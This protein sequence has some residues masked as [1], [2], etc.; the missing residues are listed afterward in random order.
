MTETWKTTFYGV[1]IQLNGEWVKKMIV[2]VPT[3]DAQHEGLDRILKV[4]K[5]FQE[6][7]RCPWKEF[8]VTRIDLDKEVN[9]QE[10]RE[11]VR[12]RYMFI[13]L[14]S[15]ESAVHVLLGLGA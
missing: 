3:V 14:N 13:D 15:L 2:G 9:L 1:H 8:R 10:W 7:N 6:F 12:G 5:R 4:L 11:T